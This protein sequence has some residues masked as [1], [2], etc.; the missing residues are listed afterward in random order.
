MDVNYL[1]IAIPTILAGL[2]ILLYCWFCWTGRNQGWHEHGQRWT[3]CVLGLL[4]GQ[5]I[6]VLSLGIG[7]LDY[8]GRTGRAIAALGAGAAGIG[9]VIGIVEPKWWGPAW[10]R[11]LR[12]SERIEQARRDA[13]RMR[14]PRDVHVMGLDGSPPSAGQLDLADNLLH[15]DSP[16]DEW[17]ATRVEYPDGS[18]V[19]GR[20]QLYDD[21]LLFLEEH[22]ADAKAGEPP[23]LAVLSIP[24]E[25]IREVQLA[26]KLREH[27][28]GSEEPQYTERETPLLLIFNRD[29]RGM[30]L[31]LPF[32]T[33]TARRIASLAGC[34]VEE[35]R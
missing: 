26:F 1:P 5:G 9:F 14:L 23:F 18:G 15:G 10:F 34:A 12:E 19:S 30:A 27:T 28:N 33:S 35:S 6:M 29:G 3:W 32:V 17:R 20:L 4:P 31:D 13:A 21:G 16:I 24:A 25:D 7:M 11:E 22:R 8:G 2:S